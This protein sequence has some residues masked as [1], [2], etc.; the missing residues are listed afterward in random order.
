MG[1]ITGTTRPRLALVI[2]VLVMGACSSGRAAPPPASQTSGSPQPTRSSSPSPPVEALEPVARTPLSGGTATGLAVADGALWVIH[3]EDGVLSRVDPAGGV[4]T[5]ASAV[6]PNGTS[7][8]SLAGRLWIAHDSMGAGQSALVAVDP[9]SGRIAKEITV[10]GV[11]CQA[12]SAGGSVWTVDPRGTLL[13]LDPSRGEIEGETSVELDAVNGHIDLAGD[14]RG[15]WIASDTTPLTRVDA[16]T[17][18]IVK[19]V[20]VGGGIP[21]RLQADLLW[22]ASPH[23]LWAID[24]ATGRI[25]LSFELADTIETFSIAVT[26]GAIWVAARR[27]GHVGTVRRYDQ[28]THMLT[29][30][31]DVAL[32]ARLEFA[33]GDIWVLD[34]ESNE[35]LRFD[36]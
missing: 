33:F 16:E 11:C 34:A 19:R 15:L 2:V 7:L 1:A 10:P 9:S 3:F 24:P 20:D 30:Q 8:T 14:D 26:D 17:G 36:P 5:A 12:A 4:E 27:P 21:M 35:V 13:R 23:H 32:P 22:G 18:K 31:A 25:A 6:V 29:G 28:A